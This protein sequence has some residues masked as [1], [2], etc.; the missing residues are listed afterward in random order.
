MQEKNLQ[1]ERMV[2]FCDAVVAI[3]ITLLALDLRIEHSSDTHLKFIDIISPWR[4]FLAFVLSF[5]NIASF[6][7][8]HHRFFAYIKKIDEKMLRYNIAWLFFIITLPFATTL[9]S[10][11]FSDTP[12]IFLYSLNTLMITVLQNTI[13]D[14][15]TDKPDFLKKE[16][17]DDK[18]IYFLRL[19]CNLDMLNAL[20]AIGMSFISPKWAFILL[21][22]KLPLIVLANLFLRR[23]RKEFKKSS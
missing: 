10:S 5:V 12:A 14:Y 20:L 1:L 23:K 15:A 13:W 4:N 3:A 16:I 21:F 11:Y 2:F 8:T 22:T 6:W 9:V 17:I 19:F 18:T 7:T